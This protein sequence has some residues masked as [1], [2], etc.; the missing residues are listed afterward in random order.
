MTIL[1]QAF[2]SHQMIIILICERRYINRLKTLTLNDYPILMSIEKDPDYEQLTPA[3]REARK[4]AIDKGKDVS[5]TINHTIS[6]YTVDILSTAWVWWRNKKDHERSHGH[7]HG[8]HGHGHHGH[9]HG[10]SWWQFVIG[11]VIGDAAAIVPT[12]AFQRYAPSFMQGMANTLEPVVGPLFRWSANRNASTWAKEQGL[13]PNS[14]E[15]KEKAKELYRYEVD[16]LPQALVWT[17]FGVPMAAGMHRM[18]GIDNNFW[19]LA[20]LQLESKVISSGALLAG[21]GLFPDKMHQFDTWT[22]KNIYTPVAKVFGGG[23]DHEQPQTE[24]VSVKQEV[25]EARSA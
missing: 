14:A 16:H 8:H 7:D 18:V 1:Q 22:S 21:R 12:L 2:T 15:A 3:E 10:D 20:Q 6:C 11:E 23:S 9:S 5:Y 19:R 13:L 17:A 25:N 4:S 24:R